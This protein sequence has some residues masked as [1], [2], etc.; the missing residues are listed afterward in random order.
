[1]S[2]YPN[3]NGV[4][5][6]PAG[7]HGDPKT[8]ESICITWHKTGAGE[9]LEKVEKGLYL[10]IGRENYDDDDYTYISSVTIPLPLLF[11]QEHYT[12]DL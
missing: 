1:M 10:K 2:K 3:I 11:Y 5:R 4:T 6:S 8:S 9:K 7:D 12:I